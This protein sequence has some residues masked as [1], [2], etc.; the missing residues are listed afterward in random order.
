MRLL[1]LVFL[2]AC[3]CEATPSNTTAPAE[4]EGDEVVAGNPHLPGIEVVDDV[5]MT[6]LRAALA[7]KGDDYEARTRH[8]DGDAPRFINRLIEE[9]SPYL[10][11]HAHNPVNWAPWGDGAFER[12]R[13]EGKA[14]LLSIGYS[15]CHWCHVME[16]ESFEDEE[17]AAYINAHYVPI[18]VDREE[19]PD[20]DEIYMSAV[21]MLTGRGG[22]PMT[23]VLTPDGDPFFAGTYFPPRAG[24]R[25]SRRGFIEI[26]AELTERYQNSASEVVAEA[27]QLSQRIQAQAAPQPAG[28]VPSPA[29]VA[30]A[31]NRIASSFDPRHGGFGR[32]PKFPQPSR[33]G[34]LLRVSR[35]T[36][37]A[38]MRQMV[39]TTLTAM[40]AGGMY[41][42][43][44]GGFHRYSTDARWLVPHFEK[45]L[46]DNGQLALSYLEGYQATGDEDFLRVARE[47]LDYVAREMTNDEGVFYSATDAD[48]MTPA[49]HREE[50]Y[51]F[52]W[53]IPEIDALF[54][55]RDELRADLGAYH[56]LT[57][58]GN[59]EGRNILEVPRPLD[60]VA[61]ERSKTPEALRASINEA[62]QILWDAREAQRPRPLRDDKI[63]TAWNGLMISAFAKAAFVLNDPR[64]E[65]I[66]VRAAGHLLETSQDSDERLMRSTLNG[67][68]RHRAY[69]QDYSFFIAGLLDLFETTSDM[70]WF[71]AA[72][73]LQSEL[74]AHF[75]DDSRG[76]YYVTA[77]DAEQLLTRD[78][79]FTDGAVPSGNSLALDNLLRLWSLTDDDSYRQ[80]AERLMGAFSR[81]LA[82]YATG[83]PRF[84]MGVDR[85]SDIPREIVIVER[86]DGSGAPLLDVLRR[87]FLPNRVALVVR[88]NHGSDLP[89]LQGKRVMDGDA[90]AYV[91]ERGRCELPTSDPR[92]FAEQLS[93]VRDYTAIQAYDGSRQ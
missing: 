67:A 74:D 65:D 4:A 30:S 36:Q 17:I 26:L 57:A 72:R 12:A 53:T 14:V 73:R 29:L 48:S 5:L 50:G 77:D 82:R 55:G 28:D 11:Q 56:P 70:R 24:V 37:N 51:Y 20:I 59:F 45:M 85:Y 81:G 13:R 91:C 33:V 2:V 46:Y 31:A 78:K 92:V 60:L 22:W 21:Q 63:L 52:T 64:Y 69:V 40:A 19:R 58:R 76:G 44:G 27:Q 54:R 39:A 35:R 62:H 18:K 8:M 84:L 93:A 66:A 7:A 16:E 43:A 49:G 15:T 80:G 10:L 6:R 1:L 86:E 9:T 71:E 42:Q 32:A 75:L 25:G 34:L 79:P 89:L 68:V 47:T 3:R 38:Q 41:D 83:A 87:S 88:D 90:T 61:T 23:V